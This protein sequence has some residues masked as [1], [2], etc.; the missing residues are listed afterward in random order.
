MQSHLQC[1]IARCH[2]RHILI[3]AAYFKCCILNFGLR[4]ALVT[5]LYVSREE[6][7]RRRTGCFS[8]PPV[9]SK[10]NFVSLKYFEVFLKRGLYFKISQCVCDLPCGITLST[11]LALW[12]E[13]N[14]LLGGGVEL[15]DAFVLMEKVA[16]WYFVV[17]FGYTSISNCSLLFVK[18]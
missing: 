3:A 9:C 12:L 18:K 1:Y 11:A 10:W 13:S 17:L 8:T 2:P 16:L 6:I 5:S 7:V 4:W 15:V 14:S